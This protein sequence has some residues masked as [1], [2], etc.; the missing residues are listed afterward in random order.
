M[1]IT[2]M[3]TL[4]NDEWAETAKENLLEQS[5]IFSDRIVKITN[6]ITNFIIMPTAGY[7]VTCLTLNQVC[8]E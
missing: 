3:E 2:G 1:Y 4:L 5:L 6:D 7:H 8:G